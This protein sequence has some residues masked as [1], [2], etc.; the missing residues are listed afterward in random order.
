VID[1]HTHSTASDGRLSPT[2]LVARAAA[3]GVRVLGLTDHDTIAGIAEAAAAAS[4]T[5]LD[6][7]PG[8]EITAVV[9][10]VDVH[11]LG[12]FVDVASDRLAAF[13]DHQ[14]R[15][16]LERLVE[17]IDR[18]AAL[19][20]PLDKEAIIAPAIADPT[21]AAGRPWIAAALVEA[22]HVATKNEAFDVWL[23]RG[24][25]AFVP[26]QGAA[27]PDVFSCIHDAGGLASLAHPGLAK[28]DDLIPGWVAAG[29]DAV[30]AYHTDHDPVTTK[31][32]LA[33]AAALRVAVSGG[34]DY[35]GDIE[36]G[37]EPGSVSLPPDAYAALAALRR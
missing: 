25:P 13:L 17:M 31:H 23:A 36:H 32:Y 24:R 14:R 9:E 27:P 35:H 16:R 15:R 30:E 10:G 33:M 29:L 5:G 3:V 21:R 26:R 7:V 8:I 34:S 1:L 11:V 19:G 22:G 37:G 6:L 18:L 20:V 2:A 28:R 12:Y 4:R